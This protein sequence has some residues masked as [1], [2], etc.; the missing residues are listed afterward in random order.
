MVKWQLLYSPIKKATQNLLKL[1]K[2]WVNR[3]GLDGLAAFGSIFLRMRLAPCQ[4]TSS[5]PWW[6]QFDN[7]KWVSDGSWSC[8]VKQRPLWCVWGFAI[9]KL[10]I[11][12][13]NLIK[14]LFNIQERSGV[15]FYLC[16]LQALETLPGLLETG[17]KL[18]QQFP[19][20]AANVPSQNGC[21][22]L[23]I[24]SPLPIKARQA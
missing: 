8:C 23:G 10:S 5:V 1:W 11:L 18:K 7:E 4:L 6:L 14:T 3:K 9:A 12:A 2:Q 24:G 21:L 20:M 16:K 15:S 13:L 17:V 22:C 19:V